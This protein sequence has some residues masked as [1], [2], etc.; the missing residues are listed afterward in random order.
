MTERPQ[1]PAVVLAVFCFGALALLPIAHPWSTLS[2]STWPSGFEAGRIARNL[3]AGLGYASPFI[4]L[5]GDNFLAGEPGDDEPGTAAPAI[6]EPVPGRWPTAWVTPLYVLMWYVPFVLFG[7]Y[8]TASA[9]SFQVFQVLLMTLALGLAWR[10]VRDRFGPRA[11]TVSLVFL[12]L[13]PSTWYFAVKDTQG[14]VLFVVFLFASLVTLASVLEGGVRAARIAHGGAVAFGIL[15]EPSSLLFYAWLEIWAARRLRRSGRSGL[16]FLATTALCGM[17]ILGPWFVRNLV[18]LKA[19]IPIKSNLAMEIYYGNNPDAAWDM[20]KAHVRRFPAW[21]EAERLKVLEMG[22]PAYAHLSLERVFEFVR[23]RP[24]VA[25]R[26]PLQ[27][28][29]YFWSYN[30]YRVTPWRPLWTTVFHAALALWIFAMVT[31][32]RTRLGWFD[33]AC[34]GFFLL[35]PIAYYATQFMIYR[36]RY[37]LE[38]L[39]LIAAGAGIARVAALREAA[40]GAE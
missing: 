40:A 11:A 8:T 38:A 17:A 25:L 2:Y 14:T 39:L 12:V 32:G 4:A 21:N 13:Y 34:A 33:Q 23:A 20:Y 24:L 5:P 37:P 18:A 22:E 36:Y 10:L 16:G 26:L 31:L 3:R 19:P 29:I 35:F 9:V 30:P 6:Q 1:I 28:L 27:R 7:T 15:V